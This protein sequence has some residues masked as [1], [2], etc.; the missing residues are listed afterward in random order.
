MALAAWRALG[1]TGQAPADIEAHSAGLMVCPGQRA[2]RYA[3]TAVRGWEQDLSTHKSKLLSPE[4]AQNADWLAVMSVSH[5]LALQENFGIDK[6]KI[7]FLGQFDPEADEIE[8]LDPFGGS[9]EAYETCALRIQRAVAGL[10]T[11][12]ERGAV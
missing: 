11:A 2:S 5:A 1:K 3:T 7:I 10:A 12:I 4:I 8:I 9:H 6:D